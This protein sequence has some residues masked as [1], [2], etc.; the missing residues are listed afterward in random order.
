MK[1]GKDVCSPAM[2]HP[3]LLIVFPCFPVGPVWV[4]SLACLASPRLGLGEENSSFVLSRAGLTP[5]PVSDNSPQLMPGEMQGRMNKQH[6]PRVLSLLP[7]ICAQGPLEPEVLPLCYGR[8]WIFFLYECAH[9]PCKLLTSC[10]E[11]FL[12][13]I[14]E[15]NSQ[16]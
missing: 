2:S 8:G 7:T 9:Y 15:I 16:Q 1:T 12:G 5:C 4:Q 10:S 6:I 11:E 14:A 13:L 3:G